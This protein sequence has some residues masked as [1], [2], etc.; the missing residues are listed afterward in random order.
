MRYL[1]ILSIRNAIDFYTD[2]RYNTNIN[3]KGETNMKAQENRVKMTLLLDSE[4]ITIL[5]KYSYEATGSTNVSKA[6]MS[7]A[8]EH[9]SRNNSKHIVGK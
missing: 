1:K 7:M 4:T 3:Y 5:K 6:V 8:K 9:E 2:S